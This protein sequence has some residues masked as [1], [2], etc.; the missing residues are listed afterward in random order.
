MRYTTVIDITQMPGVYKNPTARL[1]YLHLCLKAGYHDDDR[2]LCEISLRNLAAQVGVTLSA[3]RHAIAQLERAQLLTRQGTMWVVRKWV[4][5]GDITP[6]ARTK[7][8]QQQIERAA[9]RAR[10]NEQREREAAIE[11]QRRNDLKKAG[12]T[13]FMLWYERQVELA[14]A[15]NAEAR[16]AVEKHR[17][18]YE[19]HVKSI[20]N[21]EQ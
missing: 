12:K 2:D 17:G 11:Q 5:E 20:K 15:G 3:T 13:S 10:E 9:E 16:A 14:T 6:R 7:K 19:A 18:T 8:Q 1:V 21:Q 4:M